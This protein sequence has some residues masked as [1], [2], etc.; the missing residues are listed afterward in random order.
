[1]HADQMATLTPNSF[2]AITALDVLEHVP[3]L[4]GT[5]RQLASL[6]KPGGKLIVCGPTENFLYKAGRWLAGFS[7]DYHV[8]D[9]KDIRVAAQQQMPT[10]SL[11][12][13]YPFMPL[14]RLFEATKPK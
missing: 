1:L 8:R 2:D 9:I 7:G 5:I 12:T 6:L 14:F 3:D 13:L 4:E 10:V 11:G